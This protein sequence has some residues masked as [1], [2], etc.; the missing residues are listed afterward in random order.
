SRA[1]REAASSGRP[2]VYESQDGW[3]RVEA[4]PLSYNQQ[5]KCHKVQEKIYQDGRLVK[6]EIKEICEGTKTERTY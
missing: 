2:V 4:Q 3:Q 6:D 5:T 1:A